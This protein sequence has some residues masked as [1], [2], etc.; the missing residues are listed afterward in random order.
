MPGRGAPTP[1]RYAQAILQLAQGAGQAER[2]RQDLQIMVDAMGAEATRSA[3]ES[4]GVKPADRLTVIKRALPSLSPT[5]ANFM[6]LIAQRGTLAMLPRIQESF[7]KMMDEQQGVVRATATTA[8]PLEPAEQQHVTERLRA[9]F[10][11]Q[12]ILQAHVDPSV[13]GGMIIRAGDHVI[14]GSTRG[15]LEALRKTLRERTAL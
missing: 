2:W 12:I 5:G 1:R 9:L 13:L 15:K 11:Q 10:G 7:Q 4:P 6:G 14:D 3:L 8:V